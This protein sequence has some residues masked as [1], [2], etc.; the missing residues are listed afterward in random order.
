MILILI[1]PQMLAYDTC[2]YSPLSAAA[3]SDYAGNA[4]SQKYTILRPTPNEMDNW[5]GMFRAAPCAYLSPQPQGQ[6]ESSGGA[7]ISL[8]DRLNYTPSERD[9]GTCGN[10]WAWAG[11]GILELALDAQLGISDRLSMQYINSNYNGGTGGGWS[12]CGGWLE[13]LTQFYSSRKMVVP[14]SNT[15]AKW[16]DGRMTC[17]TESSVSAGSISTNPHY[18]L[19][20]V[21]AVTIPT[22]GV[23]KEKAIA[24][25][26]N[27]LD[28]GKGVWFGFFLPNQTAWSKFFE[29]WGYQPQC[30]VWHF[31]DSSTA[32]NFNEGGGHAVLCVGYDDENPQDR[33]WIMLNSWGVTAERPDGLFM[34]SMDMNY[35]GTYSGLGNAYYWMTL[36]ANFASSSSSS[37]I[38]AG[39]P[40]ADAKAQA[41]K[42]IAHA[43]AEMDN[44]RADLRAARTRLSSRIS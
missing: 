20:S 38:T 34:A 15:N 18:E 44:A 3:V 2:D 7:H 10:C 26:K 43:R 39:H 24:N 28:Q 19:T 23:E 25:I 41:W 30:A 21:Q 5:I 13:D 33:Y 9:Q 1:T 27:V 37:E 17:E 16:Q 14:W 8:L 42:R 6:F 36:D 12:C 11:N 29:F 31:E 32:Y 4:S 22:W 40:V 35:S